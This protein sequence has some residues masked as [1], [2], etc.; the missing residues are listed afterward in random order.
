MVIVRGEM[1]GRGRRP[2]DAAAWDRFEDSKR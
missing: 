2:W 1:E